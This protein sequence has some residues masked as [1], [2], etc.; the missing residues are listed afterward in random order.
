MRNTINIIISAVILLAA[1]FFG[2]YLIDSQNVIPPKPPMVVQKV[3]V[4]TVQNKTLPVIVT[5]NGNLVAV[6]KVE[7]YAEVQGVLQSAGKLFREGQHYSAGESLLR[8]DASEFYA[9]VQSQ[10]S[11]FYNLIASVMPDLKL[12]YPQI[13]GKWQTYLNGFDINKSVPKLPE[14]TSDQERLF[15]AGRNVISTYY[16]V[17]NL[18]ERLS[19]YSIRAPFSGVLTETLVTEGTLVRSG[20]KLGEY[21]DPGLYELEVS[22]NKSFAEYLKLNEIVTLNNINK[23]QTYQGKIARINPRVD[24]NSQTITCYISVTGDNL[25]EGLY[26][27]AAIKGEEVENV[28]EVPRS[29]LKDDKQLFVVKNDSILDLMEV[30]P[31]FFGSQSVLVQGIPDG[32]KILEKTVPGAYAGMLV[33]ILP[34]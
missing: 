7:L 25:Q 10:K 6:K 12:D 5:A 3:F 15:L 20:Q 34:Q 1:I 33:T 17:K 8:L 19:K 21:I 22:V 16:N 24:L 31:V 11:S 9:S 28:I 29:M 23:T 4:D 14:I 27:E 30:H 2:K 13:F 26:L 32:T 18:E